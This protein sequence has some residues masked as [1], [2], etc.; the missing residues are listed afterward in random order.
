MKRILALLCAAAA[1]AALAQASTHLTGSWVVEWNA[2][3]GRPVSAVLELKEGSGTWKQRVL[4]RVDD[5]CVKLAAP[6]KVVV[7]E[8]QMHLA[9]TRSA[10]LGG[11][12]DSK[13]KLTVGTDG[14]VKGQWSDQREL[15]FTKQ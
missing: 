5:P 7:E 3:S 12:G 13:I 2:P 14:S 15:K 1:C 6:A 10:V 4:G 8:E 9:I 11:C